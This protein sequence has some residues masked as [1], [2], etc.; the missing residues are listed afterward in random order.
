MAIL[1]PTRN[2]DEIRVWAESQGIVPANIEPSRVDSEPACMSLLHK[3]TA[4]ETAFVNEMSWVDF[5]ACFDELGLAIV[6]DDATV[7]NEI[8]QIDDLNPAKPPAYRWV[9]S[10]H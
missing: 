2:H 5:F 7:F 9:T 3:M 10:H 6:Y 4:D 1:G 8:L